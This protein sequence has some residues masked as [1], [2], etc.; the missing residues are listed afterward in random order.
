MSPRTRTLPDVQPILLTPRAE[1]FDHPDWLF[2]PKYD[3]FRG[4]FYVTRKGCHIR[5]KRG[6]HLKRFDELCHWVRDELPVREAILDGEVVALDSQ[7]RQNFRDLLAGRGNLH[8]AAFDALGQWKGSARPVARGCKRAL[9]KLVWATS[10]VLSQVFT[11]AERGRDR[12]AAAERIDLEGIVAKRK[13]SLRTGDGVVQDQEQGLYQGEG[14]WELF[15]ETR[16]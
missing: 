8:Y 6:N 10:T 12:F 13:G 16:S 11:I 14:R 4:L 2:E 15:Q 1:P 3:G 7:G 5:S 9:G